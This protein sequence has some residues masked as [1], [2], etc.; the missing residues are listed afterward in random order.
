M[1]RIFS[2]GRFLHGIVIYF[3][4]HKSPLLHKVAKDEADFQNGVIVQDLSKVRKMENLYHYIHSKDV[5][6]YRAS[7]EYVKSKLFLITAFYTWGCS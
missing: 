2:W 1:F 7:E 3:T 5:Q 6:N 4:Y